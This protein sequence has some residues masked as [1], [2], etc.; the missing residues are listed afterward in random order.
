MSAKKIT[1]L[2]VIF[3]VAVFLTVDG[4]F[5]LQMASSKKLALPSARPSLFDVASM[6]TTPA[7]TPQEPAATKKADPTKSSVP[8]TNGVPPRAS[9]GA[10]TEVASDTQTSSPTDAT[11]MPLNPD[12][13]LKSSANRLNMIDQVSNDAD[14]L[15]S[16]AGQDES[17]SVNQQ[18]MDQQDYRSAD[19]TAEITKWFGTD[20]GSS[21]NVIQ[22]EEAHLENG[23][24]IDRWY[25]ENGT[26]QQVMHQ[27]NK[28]NS[29]SVY[30]YDTGEIE[31]TRTIVNGNE[32]FIRFDR[33]GRQ[34]QKTYTPAPSP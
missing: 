10:S 2:T 15:F 26:V 11:Q 9:A 3:G 16:V 8:P 22:A 6:V 29:Y 13:D 34:I 14:Q 25:N 20:D 17:W 27:Y 18:S 33:E 24:L 1:L 7:T 32:I 19:G 30:R 5:A 21:S 31:A 28:D 23:E 12:D 4:L